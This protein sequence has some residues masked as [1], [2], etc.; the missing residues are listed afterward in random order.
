MSNIQVLDDIAIQELCPG[1]QQAFETIVQLEKEQVEQELPVAEAAF[2]QACYEV[3]QAKE[4]VRLAQLS[5]DQAEKAHKE[6]AAISENVLL[7]KRSAKKKAV[8]A[9]ESLEKKKASF[10]ATLEPLNLARAKRESL[11]HR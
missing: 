2:Q 4:T 10:A 7:F 5:L 9:L 11:R 8:E 6:A 3:Q 1:W